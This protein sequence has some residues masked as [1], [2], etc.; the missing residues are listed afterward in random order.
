MYRILTAFFISLLLVLPAAAEGPTGQTI[1]TVTGEISKPNRKPADDFADAFFTSHDVSFERAASFDL[2]SLEALGMK[3]LVAS[4]P[5]WPKTLTFQGPLLSD[6]LKAVGAEGTKLIV[7]ALDGYAPEIPV[8]DVEK[9]PVILA[10]KTDGKYLGIGDRGPSWIIYP[11][12]DYTEL[13]EEDDA[14][15]VWSVYHIEVRK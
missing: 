11:R 3:T 7:R 13:A 10:L 4:Y 12:N 9:Y 5:D 8:A 6:V 1:L 15:F 2:A 14:K